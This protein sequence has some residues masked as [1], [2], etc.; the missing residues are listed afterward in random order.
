MTNLICY[1]CCECV[2]RN[3][4]SHGFCK[5]EQEPI[6]GLDWNDEDFDKFISHIFP[7]YAKYCENFKLRT[8][9]AIR[10]LHL[11]IYVTTVGR[12]QETFAI[13]KGASKR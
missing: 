3:G 9:F 6:G 1:D 8:Q 7:D 11:V 13:L 4:T 5:I 12:L 2:D 10:G